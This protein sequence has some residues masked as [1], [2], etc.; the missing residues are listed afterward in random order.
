M[1][2]LNSQAVE[3][4]ANSMTKLTDN[5]NTVKS[6]ILD[7]N[8]LIIG[9]I[10][11]PDTG[12]VIAGNPRENLIKALGDWNIPTDS[13]AGE[14]AR[15]PGYF[16]VGDTVLSA[17][18]S[19]NE[20]KINLTET[21]K[22]LVSTGATERDIRRAYAKN[23]Y[24]IIHPLQARRLIKIVNSKNLKRISFSIAR[25]IESI[26]KITVQKAIKRL[27][28]HEAFDLIELIANLSPSDTV[29]WHKPVNAHVRANI[30]HESEELGRQSKMIHSSLPIII[31]SATEQSKLPNIV[32]NKPK[33][34]RKK[35]SDTLSLN[36]IPLPFINHGYM[37]FQS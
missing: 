11:S 12:E 33:E 13:T 34:N 10:L 16:L 26:E 19:L 23:G 15:Y 8:N 3:A 21:T 14:V 29:R 6:H 27:E 28:N 22:I 37:S 32:F 35:R 4:I 18:R 31:D 20:A 2:Q 24:P 5:F 9:K 1:T 17:I 7:K 30:V 36:K 25:R